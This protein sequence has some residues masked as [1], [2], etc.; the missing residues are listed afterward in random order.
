MNLEVCITDLDNGYVSIAEQTDGE[1]YLAEDSK[2][3]A[4]NRFA[5]T[6]TASVDLFKLNATTG[7]VY[8]PAVIVN[9]NTDTSTPEIKL[10]RDGWFTSIHIVIPTQEWVYA[11]LTKEGSIINVYDVVYFTD[12][13]EFFTCTNGVINRTTLQDI[14][15]ET[16]ANTTISRVDTD[17][18][19]V[20]LLQEDIT[21][22]YTAI[23]KKRMYN[24]GCSIDACDANRLVSAMNLIRHYVRWGQL[25]EAERIV[26]KL[27]NFSE[28]SKKGT[29]L[30][31]DAHLIN[32]CGCQ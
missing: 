10:T 25:A 19:S 27:G 30:S 7:N 8:T 23:F 22:T 29:L 6:E 17:Y 2:L 12:G 21:E 28:S 4:K 14:L 1:Q 9:R 15:N 26:E 24:G 20:A 32:G 18:I 16:S 11:E 13:K 31:K 5:Y 3:T